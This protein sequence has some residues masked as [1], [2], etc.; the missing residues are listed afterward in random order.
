MRL[1]ER[2]AIVTGAASGIGKAIANRFA[3]EG[4]LVII[5]DKNE[6]AIQQRERIPPNGFTLQT[7]YLQRSELPRPSV[8]RSQ[9]RVPHLW[10]GCNAPSFRALRKALAPPR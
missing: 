3:A 1:Q 8:V 9:R 6:S 5:A 2:V 7:I 4:A 10:F